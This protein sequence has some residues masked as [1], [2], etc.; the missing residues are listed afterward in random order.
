MRGHSLVETLLCVTLTGLILGAILPPVG[1]AIRARRVL[2][3][4]ASDLDALSASADRLR[5]A[6]RRAKG[7]VAR[8]GAHRTSASV[9]ALVRLDGRHEVYRVERHLGASWLVRYELPARPAAQARGVRALLARAD[10]LALRCDALPVQRA[11][12]V[13]FDLILPRRLEG[14]RQ[15]RLSTRARVGGPR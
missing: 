3:K 4:Q 9:L 12:A 13:A 2:A 7:V 10:G 15:R 1:Q 8:A 5:G 11:R 14:A 6:L